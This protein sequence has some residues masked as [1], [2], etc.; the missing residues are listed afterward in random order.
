MACTNIA[1]QQA[2]KLALIEALNEHRINAI[3]EL[4]RV[5]RMFAALGSSDLTQPMTSACRSLEGLK[6]TA[7]RLTVT[8]DVLGQ[9]EQPTRRTA[10]NDTRSSFQV[11]TM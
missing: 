6:R 4:R 9:F 5:E 8:R 1:Q 3:G 7:R 10:D 11:S 2:Q